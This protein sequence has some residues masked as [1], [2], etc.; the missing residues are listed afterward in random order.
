MSLLFITDFLPPSFSA[1]GQYTYHFAK[2][3]SKKKIKTSLIGIGKSNKTVTI[4]LRQEIPRGNYVLHI[5]WL[6]ASSGESQNVT[7]E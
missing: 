7:L 1:T 2:R 3:Y 6:G 5:E 4:A